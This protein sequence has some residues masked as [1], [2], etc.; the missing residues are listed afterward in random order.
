MQEMKNKLMKLIA[1]FEFL[2][3]S[4]NSKAYK[5]ILKSYNKVLQNIIQKQNN[6]LLERDFEPLM[7]VYRIFLEVRPKDPIFGKYV[8]REMQEFYELQEKT[9]AKNT[10][11]A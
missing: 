2:T 3:A 11:T 1:F 8:M 5:T 4:E 6:E 10:D 9:I 7:N